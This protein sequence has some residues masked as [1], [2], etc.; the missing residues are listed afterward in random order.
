MTITNGLCTLAQLK[1]AL[2]VAD[3][4]DDTALELA[5]NAASRQIEKHCG[6]NFTQDATVSAR[7]FAAERCFRVEVD[8]ISTATGLIV[9]TGVVPGTFDTTWTT[10]DYQLEPLN[11]R[12]N[13]QAWP[14][15]SLAAIS[16]LMF[17]TGPVALVQVT[18]KWGWAAIPDDVTQAAVFQAEYL[19]KTNDVPLGATSFNE[20]G[21]LRLSSTTKPLHP[22]AANLLKEYTR[23]GAMV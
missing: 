4:T 13:A 19:F 16:G 15:T 8:D 10:A 18:A 20:T 5:I 7:V 6:R 9:K 12:R 3:T 2:R 1:V 14:Y 21:I 22:V 11:G 23:T 17:P